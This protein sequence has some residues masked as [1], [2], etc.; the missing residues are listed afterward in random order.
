MADRCQPAPRSFQSPI[1]P[2]P[3][4]GRKGLVI[5]ARRVPNI[6]STECGKLVV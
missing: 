4:A 2:L 6:H 5:A 3:A 1:V